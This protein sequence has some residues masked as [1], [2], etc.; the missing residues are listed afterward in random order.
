MVVRGCP[1]GSWHPETRGSASR[2]ELTSQ[3]ARKQLCLQG[4]PSLEEDSL[5]RLLLRSPSHPLTRALGET[6]E[7]SS[8]AGKQEMWLRLPH[9]QPEWA[10]RS[11][12]GSPGEGRQSLVPSTPTDTRTPFVGSGRE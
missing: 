7:G 5:N 4:G 9:H 3:H 10:S 2:L 6:L 12:V 8:L 11:E 1:G